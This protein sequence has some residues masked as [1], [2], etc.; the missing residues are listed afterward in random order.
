MG[1]TP[2][3]TACG[4]GF[5]SGDIH[6]SIELRNAARILHGVV[7]GVG[8]GQ[9][10][11]A[12]AGEY[13]EGERVGRRREERRGEGHHP[14]LVRLLGEVALQVVDRVVDD[15]HV[16]GRHVALD[17]GKADIGRT[18]PDA[19]IEL[20]VHDLTQR[21]GRLALHGLGVEL[22]V[23]RKDDRIHRFLEVGDPLGTPFLTD[24]AALLLGRQHFSLTDDRNGRRT[25]QEAHDKDDCFFHG[26]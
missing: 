22:E 8:D 4:H 18:V 12:R 25:Q 21:T 5:G 16:V 15:R 3:A 6:P 9:R 1:A 7:P 26:T 17:V 10:R 20:G 2:R 14:P 23:A 13:L 24:F 19:D 11:A